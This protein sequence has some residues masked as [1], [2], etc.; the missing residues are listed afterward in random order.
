[1]K[2]TALLL[3]EGFEEV[4]ALTVADLLRRAGIGCDMLSLGESPQV[5]GS[6]GISVRADG[7]LAGACLEEY[8]CLVL[9]GGRAG[10]ER[11]AADGRVRDALARF[12]AAGKLIA[13][14][15]AAPTVLGAAGLLKGRRAVCYPGMEEKLTGARVLYDPVVRD[16]AVITSRGL[17]TAIPFALALV[18]ALDSPSKAEELA[19]A[20][21]Y[22]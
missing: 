19:K 10:T 22:G 14:I 18:S 16:G 17:G 20:I 8:D 6:H 15:C 12:A 1:M 21:V 4:E 5:A 9:P 7:T 13:A 2:K 3:A 11:L